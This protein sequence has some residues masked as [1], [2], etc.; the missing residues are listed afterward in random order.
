MINNC[1]STVE[2]AIT[3]NY[4]YYT[5]EKDDNVFA[6]VDCLKKAL[7]RLAKEEYHSIVDDLP[8][9]V[10]RFNENTPSYLERL[11]CQMVLD[12]AERLNKWG[13]R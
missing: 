4:G 6:V 2:D 12:E 13:W 11:G 1:N 9:F 3:P 8:G 10:Q 7:R 5:S